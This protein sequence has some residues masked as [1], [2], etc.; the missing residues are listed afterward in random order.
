MVNSTALFISILLGLG[1]FLFL[2][3]LASIFYRT[4]DKKDWFLHNLDVKMYSAF[5]G[6]KDIEE[7]AVKKGINVEKYYKDCDIAGEPYN[8]HKMIMGINYGVTC[9]IMFVVVGI[10]TGRIFLFIPGCLLFLYITFY[11]QIRLD[12]IVKKKK[13]QIQ[14][15]LPRFLDL[16]QSELQVGITTEMAICML[17]SKFNGLLSREMM[18]SLNEVKLGLH[19]WTKA[20]EK[21]AEKYEI[22]ILS[23]FVLDI[24]TAHEKGVSV[25]ASV[26]R[27][28]KDIHTTY[29][30]N[31]K[32]RAGRSTNTI[33]IPIAIFQMLPMLA[34]LIIPILSE[35]Q[36]LY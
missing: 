8:L 24:T 10:V 34:V 32:E 9:L 30:L 12:N 1:M 2:I 21:V 18:D 16:L 27:M 29:L 35:I 5:Y 25:A 17:C 23:D 20:L 7:V 3:F 4:K 26:T 28:A 11:E 22:E 14:N 15:E 31:A 19:G 36:L 6:D 33:L 13:I